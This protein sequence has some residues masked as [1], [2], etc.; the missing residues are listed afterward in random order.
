MR[1]VESI[2]ALP[3][4]LRDSNA[5]IM[6]V[7]QAKG[8]RAAALCCALHKPFVLGALTEHGTE[9]PGPN[10]MCAMPQSVVQMRRATPCSCLRLGL[11]LED[12]ERVASMLDGH[13]ASLP[14]PACNIRA[15]MA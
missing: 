4:E 12:A 2:E 9:L 7:P 1:T 6:T 11:T 10:D 5:I 14:C 15:H 13:P 8:V 3:P